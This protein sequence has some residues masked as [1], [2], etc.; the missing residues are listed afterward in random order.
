MLR[1]P[2]HRRA[3]PGERKRPGP[4]QPLLGAGVRRARGRH[5]AGR[6][7]ARPGGRSPDPAQ[8]ARHPRR[9]RGAGW[10]SRRPAGGLERCPQVQARRPGS[11]PP[12]LLEPARTGPGR[13]AHLGLLSGNRRPPGRAPRRHRHS[14]GAAGPAGRP[15]L[16]LLRQPL[17]IPLGPRHLGNRP[18]ISG[19]ADPTAAGAPRWPG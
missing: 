18:A 17:G 11:L 13:A 7:A 8:P 1:T 19:H 6:L 16:H 3:H 15:G 10:G 2:R 5:P 9:H 4:R 14:P 12:G